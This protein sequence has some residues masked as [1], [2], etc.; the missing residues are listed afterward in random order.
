[1]EAVVEPR[2]RVG[3]ELCVRGVVDALVHVVLALQE[4]EVPTRTIPLKVPRW[5]IV[6]VGGGHLPLERLAPLEEVERAELE[7]RVDA[8]R[9]E[10]GGHR[11]VRSEEARAEVQE[12]DQAVELHRPEGGVV[13]G[14]RVERRARAGERE[15]RRRL[16]DARGGVA[17]V[18]RG[19]DRTVAAEGAA[20]EGRR[21]A[22][23]RVRARELRGGLEGGEAPDGDERTVLRD[24]LRS[25]VLQDAVRA[26]RDRDEEV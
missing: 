20:L 4:G 18:P 9:V 19:V 21:E 16:E 2:D 26:E 24:G 5:G 14:A 17:E 8:L 15:G 23:S 12:L 6:H 7:D 13:R 25:L 11:V 1:E 22:R 10:R 3:R